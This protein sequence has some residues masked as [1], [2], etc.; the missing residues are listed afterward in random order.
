[1]LRSVFWTVV[2][3]VHKTSP[4]DDKSNSKHDRRDYRVART[5]NLSRP[6]AAAMRWADATR[7]RWLPL[8]QTLNTPKPAA[9]VQLRLEMRSSH[10]AR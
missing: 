2:S 10:L 9:L 3:S 4:W 1:M 7:E 5:L 8:L 6:R